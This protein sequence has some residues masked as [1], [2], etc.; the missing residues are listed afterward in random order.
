MHYR[1][2]SFIRK[3]K[4]A[5]LL[6]ASGSIQDIVS[7]KYRDNCVNNSDYAQFIEDYLKHSLGLDVKP[8]S[9][10]FWG[11]AWLVSDSHG[12]KILLVE[13][14]T[15]LEILYIAGSIASLIALIPLVSSGWNWFR[16]RGFH[17][18]Y[19]RPDRQAIEVRRLNAENTVIEQQVQS[20]EVFVF[21]AGLEESVALRERVRLLEEEVADLKQ[22]K[23]LKNKPVV[24]LRRRKKE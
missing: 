2:D 6:L 4:S 13:H 24:R 12:D 1:T 23:R 14:E 9:G 21:N 11:K 8:A 3:F 18:R 22:V 17:A 20:M 16:D 19:H 5:Q 7:L 10:D 15:G